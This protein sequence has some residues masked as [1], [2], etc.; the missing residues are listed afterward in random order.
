MY[1]V[2]FNIALNYFNSR[3]RKEVDTSS[4]ICRSITLHFNSR[5]RKE[6]DIMCVKTGYKCRN[7]N[8]RPR[9]EVD[10][11]FQL[12]SLQDK[13]FNSRPRKEVDTSLELSQTP[14]L[15]FQLTTSQGGR[16]NDF[17]QNPEGVAIST[18]DLARR[19]TF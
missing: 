10:V 6:V 9:K 1:G 3:P 7:F 2:E 8:S 18:H 16:L 17:L 19:S 14:T 13:H 5:P 15:V 12:V 11:E 4:Q